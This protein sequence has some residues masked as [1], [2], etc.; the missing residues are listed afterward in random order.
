MY[1]SQ[2]R[3]HDCL[4]RYVFFPSHGHP[5]SPCLSQYFIPTPNT[6]ITWSRIVNFLSSWSAQQV[7]TLLKGRYQVRKGTQILGKL[8]PAGTNKSI[9][10]PSA[11]P[12]A[13]VVFSTKILLSV[14]GKEAQKQGYFMTPGKPFLPQA[15]PA[16]FA[17][18][19]LIENY[20][21]HLNN[22]AVY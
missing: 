14:R 12:K 11:P 21:R 9:V 5:L 7:Y 8:H 16:I 15:L 1:P 13:P 22:R 2:I 10:A 6:G 19:D 4:N 18:S 17:S 20:C 3:S